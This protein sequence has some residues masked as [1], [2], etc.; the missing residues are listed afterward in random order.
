MSTSQR[1]WN[2]IHIIIELCILLGYVIGLI[3]FG[4]L[5]SSGWVVPFTIISAVLAFLLGN[6]T[7]LTALINVSLSFL[8]FIPGLGYFPRIIGC[9]ISILNIIIISNQRNTR[10]YR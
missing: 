6:G 9:V 5:W 2:S 10:Y 1:V 4:Y 7:I 3:P 8:G